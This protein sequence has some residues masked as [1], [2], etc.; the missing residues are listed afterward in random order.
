MSFM[1][2]DKGNF[3]N[4]KPA[5][6]GTLSQQR[7]GGLSFM[8]QMSQPLFQFSDKMSNYSKWP[9][10]LKKSN[11]MI[12]TPAPSVFGRDTPKTKKN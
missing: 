2:Y 4:Q 6:L 9:E 12:M 1:T 5:K 3:Q 11:N 7:E 10:T 8:T